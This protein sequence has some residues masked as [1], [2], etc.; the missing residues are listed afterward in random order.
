MW[1]KSGWVFRIQLMQLCADQMVSWRAY[2]VT[3]RS[4][5][6]VLYNVHHIETLRNVKDK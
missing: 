5:S 1:M 3:R 2:K 4:N 6:G